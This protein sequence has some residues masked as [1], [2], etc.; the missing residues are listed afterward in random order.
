[1][2]MLDRLIGCAV[3]KVEEDRTAN[4]AGSPAV[5][6]T[7]YQAGYEPHEFS[8]SKANHMDD[9]HMAKVMRSYLTNRTKIK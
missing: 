9:E 4:I 1:M 3:Y 8:F 6:F 2:K 5:K 7:V